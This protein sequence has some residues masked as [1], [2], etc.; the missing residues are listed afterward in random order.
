MLN[1]SKYFS[2]TDVSVEVELMPL[3]TH[4]HARTRIGMMQR[5]ITTCQGHFEFYVGSQFYVGIIG[6]AA[7]RTENLAG[8]IA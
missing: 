8:S 4:R 5:S 3:Q 2:E 7:K 6:A 1:Y